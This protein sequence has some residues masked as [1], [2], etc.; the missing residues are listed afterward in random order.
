MEGWR[1][2]GMEGQRDRRVDGGREIL[3]GGDLGPEPVRGGAALC[4]NCLPPLLRL[5]PTVVVSG[6]AEEC[7][8]DFKRKLLKF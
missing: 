1:D 3:G 8:G 6:C 4:K 7:W 2:G 5:T